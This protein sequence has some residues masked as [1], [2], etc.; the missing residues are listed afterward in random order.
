MAFL[1]IPTFSI[2]VIII[3]KHILGR[4]LNHLT[5]YCIIWSGL[6]LFYELKLISYP[7]IT[8]RAWFYIIAAFLSFFLGTITFVSARNLYADNGIFSK[9]SKMDFGLFLDRGQTVKY[10]VIFFS[11]ISLYGAYQHWMV[12]IHK[13]GSI[14]AVFL[15]ASL[16]YKLNAQQGGIKGMVPFISNF[17]YVA[18]FFGAIYTAYKGR[19][20]FITFLP[21]I[22]IILQELATIG[23]LGML[24][25]LMEFL[26][27]FFLFR[28]L[29]VNDKSSRFRFS[30]KN[31]IVAATLLMIIFIV[32][33]SFVRITRGATESYSG[34]TRELRQLKNNIIISPSLYLYISSDVGVLTKYLDS[35]GE[36]T[37]FGQNTFLTLYHILNKFDV[38]DRGSDY[39]KGYYIPMWT[40]TGTYIRELHAD[41]GI[42][43][44]LLGPYLLGLIITW[45]WY[46]FYKEK[47][48]IVLTILVYLYLIIGFSF[49]VMITR[50]S[51][52]S[53][54]QLLIIL[55]IPIVEKVARY[56]NAHKNPRTT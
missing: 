27:T 16:V 30:K 10:F 23:R 49:L 37:G 50:T 26:F 55:F 45:L 51:Y 48:F 53:I 18:I 33:A 52:W 11:L 21:F 47:S 34:A 3:G 28:N 29:L 36:K 12:L 35:E 17:G 54:S 4:W 25:A 44:A 19:F 39:Q 7:D 38:I 41:F 32:S 8:P 5:L 20:S 24:L 42:V 56:I 2:I 46:K 40:N 22:G 13:F 9:K 1:L 14:P 43:G 31:A 15:N 6:I